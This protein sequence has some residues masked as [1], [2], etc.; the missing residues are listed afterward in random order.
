MKSLSPGTRVEQLVEE[1]LPRLYKT[2]YYLSRNENEAEDVVQETIARLLASVEKDAMRIR[3]P[4]A[5]CLTVAARIVREGRPR[6]TMT[7]LEEEPAARSE[8]PETGLVAAEQ[9]AAV[10][11]CVRE[12]PPEEREAVCLHVFGD[13]TI[14]ETARAAKVSTSTAH[15]RLKKGLDRLRR[16]L[17]PAVGGLSPTGIVLTDPITALRG[18]PAPPLPESLASGI[19]HVVSSSLAGGAATSLAGAPLPLG[20]IL[21][22][23]GKTVLVVS[24]A[25]LL[26]TAIGLGVKLRVELNEARGLESAA[27]LESSRRLA[28]LAETE[29]ENA[30]LRELLG[31][32]ERGP[33]EGSNDR[34]N[35]GESSHRAPIA[36]QEIDRLLAA[37]I[38]AFDSRDA[39]GFQSA[40]LALLDAGE[41]AHPAVMEL[42][43]ITG[44]YNQ[45]LAAL[46]PQ[47]PGFAA[48]FVHQVSERRESL[49]SLLDAILVRAGDPD[50]ATLFA[51]DLVQVNGARPNLS[52]KDQ[53][54]AVMR[55]IERAIETEGDGVVWND[56]VVGAES[57]LETLRPKEALPGLGALLLREGLSERNQIAL[58]RGVAAIGGE[59]A[60]V[61][62]RLARDRAPPAL[63]SNLMT[64]LALYDYGSPEIE[65]FLRETVG[66]LDDPASLS[67]SLARRQDARALTVERLQDPGLERSER[68]AILE[69]LFTDEDATRREAAWQHLE[70][71]EH[72]L[73]DECLSSLANTEPR[74]MDLL[75]RR[76]ASDEV[77]D[78]LAGSMGRLDAKV[79]HRH[80]AGLETAAGSPELS[81]RTRC[82]AAAA[83][84]K[85]DPEAAARQVT[86][87]FGNASETARLEIV[88]ALRGRIQGEQAKALLGSIAASDPSEKVRAAA[89]Q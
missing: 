50:R 10:Q 37:A 63:R 77:S 44:N 55:I 8:E 71:A 32:L 86:I 19:A 62:L 82:A 27:R 58:L 64:N 60:L 17:G 51:F 4:L 2:A 57:L 59:E 88:R 3:D 75:L 54:S 81:S 20:G 80:R 83:L 61:I 84:A 45:M 16:R 29:K 24:S 46:K 76:M 70:A 21:M 56:H 78:E 79:I 47:D 38:A 48:S 65:A 9:R 6:V 41:A 53:A 35:A 15:A 22:L 67:R 14:R 34:E 28:R 72:E 52:G 7:T 49:T 87:G 69:L 23:K 5:W 39:E 74:A 1:I 42:L 40:F 73:Q 33:I 36:R 66:V 30:A 25:A 18:L 85:V 89:S 13:L 43:A 26:A 68:L 12:L 11:Q 31:R